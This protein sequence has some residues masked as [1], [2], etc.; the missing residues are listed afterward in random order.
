MPKLLIIIASTRPNRVG[1]P[2]GRWFE[3]V[4]RTAEYDYGYPV[5]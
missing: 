4:A 2:V 1:F 5:R 3:Q